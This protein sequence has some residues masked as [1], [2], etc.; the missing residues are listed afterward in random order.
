MANEITASGS[1]SF[2]KSGRS[3]SISKVGLQIDMSGL[4]YVKFTQNVGTAEEALEL[5]DITT[6][7]YCM[8]VNRSS[9]YE[10]RVRSA[11]G[12]A[13]L[14]SILPGEFAIF[15]F[16]STA[17]APFVMAVTSPAELEVFLI[18]A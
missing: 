12:V 10:I 14:V 18:E 15:R 1:L 11:T 3:A 4:D 16:A 17:S 6:L 5:G 9:T 2:N 8:M 7:G 13:A